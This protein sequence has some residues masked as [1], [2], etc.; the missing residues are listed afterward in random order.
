MTKAPCYNGGKGCPRR[1]TGCHGKCAEWMEW[2][3]IHAEEKAA[4]D[5]E[6]MNRNH[7]N[8]MVVEAVTRLRRRRRK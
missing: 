3:K 8:G 7:L 2:I 6:R 1:E 5:A 4:I